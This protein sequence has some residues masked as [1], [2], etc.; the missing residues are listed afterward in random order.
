MHRG[1]VFGGKCVE[2]LA[3]WNHQ[4][5]YWK[6]SQMCFDWGDEKFSEA[7][8]KSGMMRSGRLY[9]LVS[10][11]HHTSGNDGSV[12]DTEQPWDTTT[13]AKT[14]WRLPTPTPHELKQGPKLLSAWRREEVLKM[15][16][17]L[18]I[19]ACLHYGI[20]KEQAI[21]EVLVLNPRFVEW[22]MGFPT[23]WTELEP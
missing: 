17:C 1:L 4:L 11:A 6:T 12:S 8:P 9:P 14:E 15:G 22:M 23:G 19:R 2:L 10:L 13:T 18:G 20:K 7:L 3:K 16:S 5:S 21:G